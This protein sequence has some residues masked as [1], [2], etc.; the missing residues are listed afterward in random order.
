MSLE[1]LSC[2]LFI[3]SC[4][5]Y[6]A[7]CIGCWAEQLFVCGYLSISST[8][9]RLWPD[10]FGIYSVISIVSA[11]QEKKKKKFMHKMVTNPESSNLKAICC[12]DI[13]ST[14]IPEICGVE[15]TLKFSN[16]HLGRSILALLILNTHVRSERD[17]VYYRNFSE[18]Q[19]TNT[20][21]PQCTI[22]LN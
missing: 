15:R 20:N 3:I 6:V 8:V 22:I 18:S 19:T 10:H 7:F 2:V 17:C 5:A 11:W 14:S 13:A 16:P 9:E 1:S 4:I 21:K 12:S